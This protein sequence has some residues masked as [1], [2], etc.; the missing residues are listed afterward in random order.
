MFTRLRS[1][2]H[3]ANIT[4]MQ[5]KYPN[6]LRSH[7]KKAGLRQLE[8]ARALGLHSIERISK[9]ENGHSTPRGESLFHL[10]MLYG[11]PPEQLFSEMYQ[12]ISAP[13]FSSRDETP[14]VERIPVEGSVSRPSIQ[15]LPTEGV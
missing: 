9:W 10:A 7:R 13:I 1:I 2:Y 14:S 5:N 15:N 3:L 12:T 6:S 8:V 11:V 4:T